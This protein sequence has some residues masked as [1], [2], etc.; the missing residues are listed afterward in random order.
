[1][2]FV[3]CVR[4]RDLLVARRPAATCNRPETK[5]DDGAAR[6]PLVQDEW[7]LLRQLFLV[8][9]LELLECGVRPCSALGAMR[10]QA[11]ERNAGA[12]HLG[13]QIEHLDETLVEKH[14]P[15]LGIEQAQPVL[16]RAE[17]DRVQRQQRSQ[18]IRVA[19]ARWHSIGRLHWRR[20]APGT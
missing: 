17:R 10:E 4:L 18:L 20:A 3:L 16:Q 13:R 6:K 7:F 14:Q 8:L 11:G 12:H 2:P 15:M 9:A 1:M 19:V 5:S